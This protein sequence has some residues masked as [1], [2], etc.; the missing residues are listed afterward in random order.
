MERLILFEA[1][2]ERSPDML[3]LALFFPMRAP[4]NVNNGLFM[5]FPHCARS[6]F[7]EQGVPSES[8]PGF[9]AAAATSLKTTK[10]SSLSLWEFHHH[11]PNDPNMLS[12]TLQSDCLLLFVCCHALILQLMNTCNQPAFFPFSQPDL[13]K[14]KMTFSRSDHGWLKSSSP[15]DTE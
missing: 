13:K 7:G 8:R 14:K 6:V 5:H 2:R 15:P 9:S 12:A 1:I 10:V 3:Y 11:S 4:L